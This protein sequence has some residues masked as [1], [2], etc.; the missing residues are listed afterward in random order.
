[1]KSSFLLDNW[2]HWDWVWFI[3]LR[4]YNWRMG[5]LGDTCSSSY[6]LPRFNYSAR[7]VYVSVFNRVGITI[8]IVWLLLLESLSFLPDVFTFIYFGHVYV[9]SWVCTPQCMSG[10][11]RTAYR[12]WCFLP[13]CRFR[14]SG[15]GHQTWQQEP[16]T[17]EPSCWPKILIYL[18]V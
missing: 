1:M 6:K 3:C 5:D 13:P 9:V 16:L 15:S 12:N 18:L 10:G 14:G 11:Q 4:L 17:E 7:W 2:V 8:E